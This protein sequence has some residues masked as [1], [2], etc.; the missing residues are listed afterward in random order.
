MPSGWVYN[1]EKPGSGINSCKGLV[2]ATADKNL[3]VGADLETLIKALYGG[4][5]PES[6]Q[7]PVLID[8]FGPAP[9]V[10]RVIQSVL[11]YSAQ[12]ARSKSTVRVVQGTV[13]VD[14][15]DANVRSE[16]VSSISRGATTTTVRFWSRQYANEADGTGLVSESLIVLAADG[17]GF[18]LRVQ[19]P[20]ETSTQAVTA[21]VDAILASRKVE[22]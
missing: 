9:D 18:F 22:G 2:P 12:T 16:T 3:P 20:Q 13:S 7:F 1:V 4:G 10:D 14:P 19:K 11:E 15:P 17:S 8:Q 6:L 21:L 5:D